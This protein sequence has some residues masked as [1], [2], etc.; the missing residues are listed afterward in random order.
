MFLQSDEEK[1]KLFRNFFGNDGMTFF[2][3]LENLQKLDDSFCV[4]WTIEPNQSIYAKF[5]YVSLMDT[6]T[7]NNIGRNSPNYKS[8]VVLNNYERYSW[9]IEERKHVTIV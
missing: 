8:V 1:L 9:L 3:Y 5:H 2:G 4:V 6:P 7:S